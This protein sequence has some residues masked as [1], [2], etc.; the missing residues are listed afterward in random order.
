MSVLRQFNDQFQATF[1][2]MPLSSRI[3]TGLLAILVVVG[4]GFV[5][6]GDQKDD[7]E[8]LFGG[9]M[10][11]EQELNS[12]E[13]SFSHAGLNQWKREGRRISIPIKS[14]NEYLAALSNATSLPVAIR[15]SVQDAI[16]KTTIFESSSQRL[17]RE[18]HA[19]EQDLGNKLTA[20]PEIRWASVEYDLGQ[21]EGL[22][23]DRQQTASVVVCPEGGR[24]LSAE[25]VEDIKR[26]IGGSY[27]GMSVDDVVVIDTHAN[28]RLAQTDSL[29]DDP[30]Q[31][32]G[33]DDRRRLKEQARI[34]R[35]VTELL[36]G[37]GPIRV[38]AYVELSSQNED[39]TQ[40]P[41]P[42]IGIESPNQPSTASRNKS[43]ASRN[44]Q[45]SITSV[46]SNR[47]TRL[48]HPIS[49]AKSDGSLSSQAIPTLPVSLTRAS[50]S[51][52]LPQSYYQR[53]WNHLYAQQA[54]TRSDVVTPP[55]TSVQLQQLREQTQSNIRAAVTP[56]LL[57]VAPHQSPAAMV[58]VYDFPDLLA[59]ANQSGSVQ[60]NAK[61]WLLSHWQQ[62]ALLILGFLGLSIALKT[63]R[64]APS[65]ASVNRPLAGQVA[66]EIP[67]QIAGER[68]AA[69][70]FSPQTP[71]D[72]ELLAL[73]DQNPDVAVDVIRDWIG[74][75]A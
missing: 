32:V 21:R 30:L 12:V 7:T 2:T 46:R 34:E 70:T 58:E 3:T 66:P 23:R 42:E 68:S 40:V 8:M 28:E 5:V 64:N 9:Q 43:M 39:L 71:S 6:R 13:M 35:H 65:T 69:S 38:T 4:L 59:D 60:E 16:E 19:K 75:A 11:S 49:Q 41:Q 10:L 57:S 22:G 52:G 29:S 47:A 20:F 18:M 48:R 1:S 36:N 74:K 14:K 37:Y 51:I 56:A 33:A 15:S 53:L 55:P 44:N 26:F 24:A 67:V 73:I 45:S 25:R 27:A 62:V 17:S 72:R 31:P 63:L 54:T 61:A 50:V